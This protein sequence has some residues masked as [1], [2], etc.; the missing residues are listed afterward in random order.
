M[1]IPTIHPTWESVRSTT[2]LPGTLLIWDPIFSETNASA[3]NTLTLT[4]I[5]QAG[6]KELSRAS[7]SL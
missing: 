3:D 1:S 7:R 6:W 2:P 5:R 4:E